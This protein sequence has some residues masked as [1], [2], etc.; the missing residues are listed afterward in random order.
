MSQDLNK[1][2]DEAINILASFALGGLL[3]I[4]RSAAVEWDK[5]IPTACIRMSNKTFT[6]HFNPRFVSSHAATPHKFAALL[7]HELL[8]QLFGHQN[9]PSEQ[10]W[11]IATDAYINAFISRLHPSFQPMF[12]D[13][14]R[15]DV[16]PEAILRPGSL[17]T[18]PLLRDTYHRLYSKLDSITVPDIVAALKA[19]LPQRN[20]SA[21][22]L[23]SHHVSQEIDNGLLARITDALFKLGKQAGIENSPYWQTICVAKKKSNA[24]EKALRKALVYAVQGKIARALVSNGEYD[25]SVIP[26]SSLGRREAVYYSAGLYPMF[27]STPPEEPER[28][29]ARV[30]VDVSGSVFSYLPFLYGVLRAVENMLT[31]ECYLF[32]TRVEPITK[33]ELRQ[34]KV[35]TT[36]GTNFDCVADHLLENPTRKALIFTDGYAGIRP[37]RLQALKKANIHLVGAI[38]ESNN[39]CSVLYKMCRKVFVVPPEAAQGGI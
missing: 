1:K 7:L 20:T 28:E 38:T 22:L 23:G 3:T 27:F 15:P 24:F 17:I 18:N 13:F 21:T 25:R 16:L 5:E 32:S 6:L 29:A 11:N 19:A 10:L 33:E 35:K 31:P 2:L 8:H 26:Q 36:V 34:G 12:A 39:T 14:Y 4:L 30:Y 37:H 9:Y